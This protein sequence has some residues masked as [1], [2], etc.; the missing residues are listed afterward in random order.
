MILKRMPLGIY[1]ANC[2]LVGCEET[3][4]AMVIDP[5]GEPEE[6]LRRAKELGFSIKIILLTHAH[7]D[8]IGGLTYLKREIGCPII[9]HKNEEI[10]LLDSKLNLSANM[11]ID[12]IMMK[13]DK[14]VED[15]DIIKIGNLEALIIH[16]P[17]HTQGSISIKIKDSIITGDTLFKGSI[18]RTD[19]FGG[20][21]ED[22]ISSIKNKILIFPDETF[23]YPGHG[24]HTT[25]GHER[26][27]N[28]YVR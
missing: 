14:L 24:P 4:E 23:V 5:G 25:V 10:M 11:S 21:Y 6:I 28:P 17:G 2:Y 9:I 22:I 8:H 12:D 7:G 1:A 18:G 20:S 3:K 16:T 13:P 15:G 26:V 19:L 27:Y